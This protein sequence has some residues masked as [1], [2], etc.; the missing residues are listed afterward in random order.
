MKPGPKPKPGERYDSGR[1]KPESSRSA[2]N[3]SLDVRKAI[4]ERQ[5]TDSKW[6][7]ALGLL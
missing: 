3:P 1:L 2:A 6:G 5:A 4:I 7:S